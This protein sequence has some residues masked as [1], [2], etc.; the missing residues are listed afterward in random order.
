MSNP[1]GDW[2]FIGSDQRLAACSEIMSERGYVCHYVG[3]DHYSERLDEAILEIAPQNIVFPI[4]ELKGE[5]TS[6]KEWRKDTRLYTGIAS[7][8]WLAPFKEAGL[9]ADSYLQEEQFIWQNAILT[10]EAFVH[11]YYAR[12]KRIIA[13]NHFYVAGFGRVG[14]AVA[15]VLSALGA[16]VTVAARSDAQLGEASAF[17][18]GTIRLTDEFSLDKGNLVNTIPAKWLSIDEKC[19][20]LHVFDLASAPGCLKEHPAPEYYTILLGLPGKHFPVDAATALADA[21]E[22]MYIR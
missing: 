20:S 10:A 13:G 15:H 17:G 14:K 19:A 22:R 18:Y 21:L 1:N 8:K 9:T 12:N 7:E 16:F 4:L 5:V 2:L 11:E 6:Q 3:T